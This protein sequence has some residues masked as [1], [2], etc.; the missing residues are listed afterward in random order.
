LFGWGTFQATTFGPF[1][2]WLGESLTAVS[3]LQSNTEYG[4]NARLR[5]RAIGL[6]AR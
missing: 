4:R 3:L 6:Q 5:R 2:I 1:Q